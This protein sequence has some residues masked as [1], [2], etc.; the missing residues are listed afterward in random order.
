MRFDLF[1]YS[2]NGDVPSPSL[3]MANIASITNQVYDAGTKLHSSNLKTLIRDI[4]DKTLF[5]PT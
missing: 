5:I 1:P 2:T 4:I 3:S